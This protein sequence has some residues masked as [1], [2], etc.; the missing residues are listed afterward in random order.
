MA[1][2]LDEILDRHRMQEPMNPSERDAFVELVAGCA[3]TRGFADAL[4]KAASSQG[5]AVIAEIKRRSPSRGDLSLA[6][7]PESLVRAYVRGGA[8]CL[9][10]LTDLDYFGGTP[11]DLEQARASCSLPVLRKDFIVS[12][13]DV[14]ETRLMSAD[15][16]L[17]IVS[18]LSDVELSD[19]HRLAVAIGLDVIV[20]VHD[21]AELERALAVE[22]KVIGVNQRDLHTF[23]VDPERAVRVAAEIPEGVIRVAESG[24][25]KPNDVGRLVSAGFDA[26]LVGEALVCA[27]DPAA[28][29]AAFIDSATSPPGDPN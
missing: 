25:A 28:M 26:I 10:V 11:A 20:E 14:Y 6:L 9:S 22:V 12:E 5:I 7:D 15:A 13:R 19:F 16:M 4:G 2:Y 3:P 17:L 23:S 21:E 27:D 18:A 29:L 1:T 24:I 8:S